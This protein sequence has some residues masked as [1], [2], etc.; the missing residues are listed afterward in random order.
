MIEWDSC[1]TQAA[2]KFTGAAR[3]I[4][5]RSVAM[6]SVETN[7]SSATKPARFFSSLLATEISLSHEII[8]RQF[9]RRAAK[10]HFS[11]FQHITAMRDRQGHR[12]ILLD[13]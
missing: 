3:E 10:N 6:D 13:Q 11:G 9:S 8:T 5:E 7:R 12:G 1:Y 4:D 2:Q